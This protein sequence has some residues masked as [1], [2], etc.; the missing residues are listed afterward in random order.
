MKVMKKTPGRLD[1]FILL[2]KIWIN[3]HLF[4]IQGD[5]GPKRK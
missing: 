5:Y 3:D 2:V 1:Y 4:R